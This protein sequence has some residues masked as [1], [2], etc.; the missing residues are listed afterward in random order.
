MISLTDSE[1]LE[2]T[3]YIHDNFGV[4][5]E[6]KRA[7]IEGRLGFY[8]SNRGFESY[9]DYFDFALNDPSK[10]E[11]GN[12]LNRLTT[13]HTYFMREKEHFDFLGGTILPWI[14]NDLNDRD[15]R[16][17]SAGCSSG[18]EPYTLSMVILDYISEHPGEW[19]STIFATDISDRAL[20]VGKIG[21]YDAE[22][23]ALIPNDWLK[24]YFTPG[25]EDNYQ[26]TKQLRDNVAFK[27][28]NLLEPFTAKKPYHA[29]FCRNVMIY[30]DN[31]TKIELVRKFYDALVVGGYFL[32]GHSESLST[33]ENDFT[34]VA[35]SIYIKK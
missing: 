21:I 11:L 15:I 10:K 29:I 9:K 12:L 20:K 34:Y 23:L 5:L 13:N 33:T 22:E 24:H 17:W 7:L 4:N 25:T 16:I 6:H 2:I 3:G 19:D 27:Y 14:G 35:P 8:L 28:L 30:F 26:V 18:Q 31:Q 32:I 1:F